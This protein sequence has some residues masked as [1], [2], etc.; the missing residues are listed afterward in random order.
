MF[1]ELC[2]LC[3]Y[4]VENCFFNLAT[5]F[6]PARIY[7]FFSN[8]KVCWRQKFPAAIPSCLWFCCSNS[9][10][11]ALAQLLCNYCRNKFQIQGGSPGWHLILTNLNTNTTYKIYGTK[12]SGIV[13]Y[14]SPKALCYN[15]SWSEWDIWKSLCTTSS[16][17]HQVQGRLLLSTCSQHMYMPSLSQF[18]DIGACCVPSHSFSKPGEGFWFY[19]L[20]GPWEQKKTSK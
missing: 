1:H 19:L 4:L 20:K 2:T 17:I 7:L 11:P 15:F 18:A 5:L 3:H 10:W 13:Q 14:V 12:I 16:K 9:T 6:A 8:I